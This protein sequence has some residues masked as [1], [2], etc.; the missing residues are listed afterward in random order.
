MSR[1]KGYI[2]DKSV[3]GEKVLKTKEKNKQLFQFLKRIPIP[4]RLTSLRSKLILS[5]FI[6]IAFIIFLGIA[7]F[8]MASKGIENKYR[9]TAIQVVSQTA[10]YISFGLKT[11]ENTSM[12]YIND[13][14][15]TR[16]FLYFNIEDA[17][18]EMS[19]ALS[20]IQ[21]DFLVKKTVYNFIN[22]IHLISGNAT[23]ITSKT[24]QSSGMKGAKL[25]VEIYKN[26]VESDIGKLISSSNYIWCDYIEPLDN[27]LALNSSDY[28]LRIARKFSKNKAFIVIDVK[29]E[30]IKSII[31]E[32]KLDESGI[33]AFVSKDGKEIASNNKDEILFGDQEFYHKA[34]ESE[35]IEGASFETVNGKSYLFMYSK[36]GSTGAMICSLIPKATINSQAN[37]IRQMTILIVIIACIIAIFIGIVISTGIDKTIKGIISGLKKAANGDLTVEFKTNR[38]DEFKILIEEMQNTFTKMKDLIKQVHLLSSEVA[39]SSTELNETSASFLKSS[40][41]ISRAI[42]DIEQGIMQQAKDA[43]ECLQQMDNLSKKIGLV[44]DNTKEISQIADSAKKAIVEGTQCTQ[45]LNEQTK[46][47][48]AITTDIIN[49]IESLAEKSVTITKIIN[50]INEIANRTNLLS[51]NASIEAV[52]AGENGKSFIVVANEIR[53]LAERSKQSVNEINNIINSILEDTR[54]TVETARKVEAVIDL[55][56]KAVKNTTDSYDKINESVENLMVYLNYITENVENIEESRESTLGAIESIGAVLEE[57]AAST[58]SVSQTTNEQLN[59][60]EGLNNSAGILKDEADKLSQAIQKFRV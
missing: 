16:Y 54:S 53:N 34:M 46:S 31:E 25:D 8:N 6:P 28:A 59:S 47:T 13:D 7:S 14:D 10:D 44:S 52:R 32:A 60:V 21:S 9:D 38:S 45:D 33:I 4:K 30:T 57:I 24:T 17:K 1:K 23:G 29:A 40:E 19:E 12:E 37:D 2:N 36:I 49:A 50:V 11:V 42:N 58:N 3:K 43:E 56:E 55:Q 39:E 51:L 35:D 15:F 26:I 48:I 18:V 41:D 5:F 22:D 20:R 27:T